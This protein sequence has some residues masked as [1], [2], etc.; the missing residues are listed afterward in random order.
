MSTEQLL[1][2]IGSLFTVLGIL[3]GVIYRSLGERIKTL[4]GRD[5]A[6]LLQSHLAT[7]RADVATI[8]GQA[9]RFAG[10][11]QARET[12]WLEWRR[13]LEQQL[14]RMELQIQAAPV[15]LQRVFQSES[16]I[17]EIRDWLH[18]WGK[19]YVPRAI[20]D[21]KERM[22]RFERKVFSGQRGEDR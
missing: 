10:M 6:V 7:I 14:E 4:E 13:R 1:A 18:L 5:Y 9:E 15:V 17:V 16:F 22:D 12:A 11:D 8:E 3:V 20:D 19:P 2:L 21:L